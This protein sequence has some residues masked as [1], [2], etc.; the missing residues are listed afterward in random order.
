MQSLQEL[1]ERKMKG[2]AQGLLG[3]MITIIITVAVVIPIVQNVIAN[4]AFTGTLATIM[5]IIPTLLGVVLIVAVAALFSFK[6]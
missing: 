5:N 3:L 4:Q 6:R 1:K 2:Q